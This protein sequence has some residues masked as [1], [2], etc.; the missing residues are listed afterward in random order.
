MLSVG[1]SKTAATQIFVLLNM[2]AA[3]LKLSIVKL[4]ANGSKIWATEPLSQWIHS[5]AELSDGRVVGI[6][7][8]SDYQ[9]VPKPGA[10][11][12]YSKNGEKLSTFEAD[13]YGDIVTTN[14]GGFIMVSI[15][16]IKTVPQ[17]AYISSIWYDT[18]TVVTKYDND[19][20][21]EW[22]KTYDSIKDAI[23]FD[24]ALPLSDGSVVLEQSA[25]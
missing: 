2:T 21:V 11:N 22:R 15:R 20:K 4:D 12:C 18:E 23:G 10:V 6:Q 14:D 13:C 9:A 7:K 16:N 19:Y 24:R 1:Q 5:I 25:L 8:F 3:E 17:P